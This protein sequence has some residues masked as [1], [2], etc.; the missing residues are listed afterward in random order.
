MK[1]STSIKFLGDEAPKQSKNRSK[2]LRKKLHVGEF[3]EYSLWFECS[4]LKPFREVENDICELDDWIMGRYPFCGSVISSDTYCFGV[5]VPQPTNVWKTAEDIC[6]V[7]EE[8]ELIG[9]VDS[10][11]FGDSYYCQLKE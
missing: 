6:T 8:S 4:L 5:I 9:S 1:R 3:T 11:E 2:R 7:L 10:L